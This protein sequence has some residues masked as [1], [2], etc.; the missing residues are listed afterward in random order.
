MEGINTYLKYS[1]G[2]LKRK[3]MIG[4]RN[5]FKEFN[6][7]YG[8]FVQ[9]PHK[10]GYISD[11]DYR[12]YVIYNYIKITYFLWDESSDFI[13]NFVPRRIQKYLLP[14]INSLEK[15]YLVVDKIVF[16]QNA[17]RHSLPVPETFFYTRDGKILTI[18]GLEVQRKD[19]A[20]YEGNLMF[21]KIVDGSAAVGARKEPFVLGNLDVSENRIYQAAM[22][23]HSDLLELSPTKALNCIKIS[24]YYTNSG[25]VK[26]QLSFLKLGGVDSIVD[27][28]GGKAGGGIAVPIDLSTGRLKGIGYKEVGKELRVSRI[29]TNKK[30]FEGFKVPFYQES[31]ELVKKAH[32]EVFYELKHIGWDVGITDEGPV[33]IEGNSGADMF[34]AQMICRPFNY[35]NDDL[36]QENLIHV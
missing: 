36:I 10:M 1:M 19:L 5:M 11:F 6:K 12:F 21:S 28:I 17:I 27:N 16:Y 13:L 4:L 25:E 26:I 22:V 9:L 20:K 34:A 29:P 30:I 32:K 7:Y 24:S 3:K 15:K 33:L 14:K 18:D 35:Y 23:T 31:V 2:L 8:K